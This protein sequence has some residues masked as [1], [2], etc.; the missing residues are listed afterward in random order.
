VLVFIVEPPDEMLENEEVHESKVLCP[1]EWVARNLEI[2]G[3]VCTSTTCGEFDSEEVMT[4]IRSLAD[5]P[6]ELS[7]RA[8]FH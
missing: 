8:D 7:G 5:S 6:E 4:G 3:H 1:R 2:L